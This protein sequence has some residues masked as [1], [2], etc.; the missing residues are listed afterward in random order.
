MIP[1]DPLVMTMIYR[2]DIFAR[3]GLDP[4]KPPKDW[5]E[6]KAVSKKIVE[7]DSSI[8][9]VR[10]T[11]RDGTSWNFMPYLTSS[12]SSVLEQ[13]HDGTW[14]ANFANPKS[15]RALSFYAWLHAGLRPDNVSRGYATG[16]INYLKEGKVAMAMT[17]LGGEEMSKVDTS[18][19]KW[20]FA[21]ACWA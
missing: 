1:A 8:F 5:H 14:R 4:R 6:M 10:A 17:Y 2:K 20:G 9:A 19:A 18:G 15:A 21:P 16:N 12:G 11:A 3:A 7:Y 13:Q